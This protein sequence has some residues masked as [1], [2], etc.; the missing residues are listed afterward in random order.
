MSNVSAE[1]V[2]LNTQFEKHISITESGDAF[3]EMHFIY[4]IQRMPAFYVLNMIVPIVL[5]F[6]LSIFV[7]YLPTGMVAFKLSFPFEI[8]ADP[9][10]KKHSRK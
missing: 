10:E 4:S 2:I 7:F 8:E 6:F 1:W 5:M 3:N 9:Y